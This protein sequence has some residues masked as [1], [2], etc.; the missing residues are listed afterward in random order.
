[1]DCV[2]DGRCV[3]LSADVLYQCLHFFSGFIARGDCLV[4]KLVC[5]FSVVR[6]VHISPIYG[7]S[8]QIDFVPQFLLIRH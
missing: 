5:P 7:L 8:Q 6:D 4:T 1:M 3:H 2:N